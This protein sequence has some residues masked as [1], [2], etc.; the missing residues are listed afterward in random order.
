MLKSMHDSVR[1]TGL[2]SIGDGIIQHI[3]LPNSVKN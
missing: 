3:I 1:K 2:L